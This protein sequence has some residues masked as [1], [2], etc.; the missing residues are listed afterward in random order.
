MATSSTREPRP[1]AKSESAGPLLHEQALA[2]AACVLK[3]SSFHQ[4]G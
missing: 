3:G 1:E 4:S 2:Q